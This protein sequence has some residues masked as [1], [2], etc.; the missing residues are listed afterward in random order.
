MNPSEPR[1]I[2]RIFV[3]ET[4]EDF[5]GL[6]SVQA[7]IT[8]YL[9]P[10]IITITPRARYYSF[11][12]WLLFEYQEQHPPG[13]SLANFIKRR[14]QIFALA[15]LAFDSYKGYGDRT[16][17]M[18]GTIK[19]RQ[20]VR[21][22]GEK[23]HV[24]LSVDNY[25]ISTFGGYGQYSAVMNALGLIKESE[26]ADID[27]DLLPKSR[28]MADAFRDSIKGTQ[29]YQHRG[30]YDTATFIP[31]NLLQE[32]GEKCY[33]S[34]LAHA[35]D[36]SPVLE[37]LF[38][39]DAKHILPEP[40]RDLPTY[41]NMAGSLGMMIEM[42]A[43]ADQAFDDQVF[44]DCIMYGICP[45]FKQYQ[46]SKSL[47]PIL[48]HWRMFQLREYYVYA[49]YELWIYFLDVLRSRGPFTFDIF[50]N[51]LDE[52]V[53]CAHELDIAGIK[54]PE[55][56]LSELL[57]I[58]FIN[59]LLEQSNI[60]N[61]TFDELCITYATQYD[62]KASER[63]IQNLL[64]SG[65]YQNR[66]VRLMLAWCTLVSI[67]LRLKGIQLSD[68]NNSWIWALEGGARR[69][70]MDLFVRHMDASIANKKSLLETLDWL[71]RDYVLAQ[72]TITALEKWGQRSVNTF[73]FSYENGVYE[74]IK[75]DSNTF[76]ASRFFQAYSMIRDLGLVG[77]DEAG[78]PSLTQQGKETL[79]RIL[80]K[81]SG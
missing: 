41:G 45:D 78:I 17:G 40:G 43:Q 72:H 47:E 24:P 65:E 62:V 46:P 80:R 21:D 36:A 74:W 67:Y 1:W 53:N 7:N 16:A 32:Y 42:L 25:I 39:F 68:S 71:F 61:D 11:Y 44:R 15:N 34:G 2:E 64:E 75:M 4:G 54:V 22:H 33:L 28:K 14:E 79:N 35:A 3:E 5:L 63:W 20:H 76:T 6:R 57:T 23:D 73:H 30:E 60:S 52:R 70:S 31:M 58:E 50:R 37:A 18:I 59:D 8:G 66:E 27:I 77:L 55:K 10:G 56:K 49:L 9:L 81:F 13:M 19:I 29:Y 38:G 69:R 48:A 26:E 51:Y 12:S